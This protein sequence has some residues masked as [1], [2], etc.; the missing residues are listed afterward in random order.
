MTLYVKGTDVRIIGTL[1]LVFGVA[2]VNGLDDDGSIIWGGETKI[3][4]NSQE[5]VLRNDKP[6]WIS[7]DGGE[8]PTN[9]IEDRGSDGTVISYRPLADDPVRP[10]TPQIRSLWRHN[11]LNYQTELSLAEWGDSLTSK[12][13]LSHHG[14]ILAERDPYVNAKFE[15]AWQITE[16]YARMETPMDDAQAMGIFAVVG[17]DVD[18][19]MQS[20]FDY[21]TSGESE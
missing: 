1:E 12:D 9:A 7:E 18:E 14:L 10:V 5:T 11:V 6:V 19:L 15:G 17:D 16:A 4:W 13:W 20:A 3:D 2:Q 21:L 8:Y